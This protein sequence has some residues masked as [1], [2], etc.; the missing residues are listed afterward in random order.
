MALCFKGLPFF[1]ALND[2]PLDAGGISG[3]L[4]LPVTLPGP[5]SLH[6]NFCIS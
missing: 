3:G 5:A 2:A 1:L 6:I 4:F